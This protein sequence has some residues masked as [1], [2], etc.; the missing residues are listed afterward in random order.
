MEREINVGWRRIVAT[1]LHISK[2]NIGRVIDRRT[3]PICYK[4][5]GIGRYRLSLVSLQIAGWL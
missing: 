4:Y 3:L 5:C 2:L 1:Y